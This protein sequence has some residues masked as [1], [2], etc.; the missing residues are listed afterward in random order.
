[1]STNEV[2]LIRGQSKN[3]SDYRPI[4][5]PRI[6]DVQKTSRQRPRTLQQR[7]NLGIPDPRHGERNLTRSHNLELHSESQF[8]NRDY[9]TAY[10]GQIARLLSEGARDA[11]DP[12][13]T[14]KDREKARDIIRADDTARSVPHC[15]E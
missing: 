13:E 7:L 4:D 2:K 8:S 1:M 12:Y 14:L 5:R 6:T 9:R 11:N 10:R 3:R 15:Q